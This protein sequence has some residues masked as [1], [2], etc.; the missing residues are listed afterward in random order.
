VVT[1]QERA[2]VPMVAE[3]MPMVVVV[4]SVV[5]FSGITNQ[6]LKLEFIFIDIAKDNN[7]QDD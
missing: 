3:V 5:N 2:M 6:P 1:P 4:I 7:W